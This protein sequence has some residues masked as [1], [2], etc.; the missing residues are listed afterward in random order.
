MSKLFP[1]DD[2]Q[3]ALFEDFLD[4]GDE[5][6]G[7]DAD[8]ETSAAP[9]TPPPVSTAPAVH[10][11]GPFGRLMEANFLQFASYSICD[12]ALPMVEDGLKP[13]QRRILHAMW[14]KDD[15]RFSKVA[16]VVG[17]TMHYH[18]HGDAAIKDAIVTLAN[19]RYL[20]QGQGNF[21][22]IFTGDEA[23]AARYIE[24]RLTK[25]AR[26]YLFSPKVTEYVP[27]Y[28]GRNKEPVLLPSK[29]P[30]S[31]MLGIDG[32][33][34]GLSTAIL[35]HNF[36]EL[37]EA[38]IAILQ[39]KPCPTLVPDF[40][41]GGIMDA[42]EYNDGNGSIRVR[43]NIE[44]REGEKNKLFIT[45][46]PYGVT[47]DRLAESIEKAIKTKKLPI[48]HIDNFTAEKV[49]IEISLTPGSDAEKVRKSLYAFTECER[50]ISSRIVVLRDNRPVE[51]SVSEM[52]KH[53]A[54]RLQEIFAAEFNVR[55]GEIAQLM[56]RKTLEAI[57]IEHR[58]YKR[59]ET[60][61][62]AE[63]VSTE[64]RLGFT[65]FI[66][67]VGHELTDDEIEMLLKIP[68][69]R[70]SLYDINRHNDEMEALRQEQAEIE[71]NLQHLAR[72]S[73]KFLKGLLKEFGPQY[74]RLTEI[75]AG[76]QEID[77]RALTSTELTMRLSEDFYFG[78]DIKQGTPL[79]PCSSLDKI[80]MVWSDGRYRFMPP[81]DKVLADAMYEPE[82]E[83]LAALKP[84]SPTRYFT[85]GIYN[86]DDV[87]T[88]IYYEPIYG[89]TYIKRFRWGGMIMNKDYSL[90]PENATI[91]LL[92]KGTPEAVYVKFKYMKGQRI[93][94][95]VFDPSEARITA[96][97][98][99]GIQMTPK[100]IERIDINKPTWWVATEGNT[101]GTLFQ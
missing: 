61:K 19:K 99:K 57:F 40:I 93:T 6:Q 74:P 31:L 50:K 34:V 17:N 36:A 7:A 95:Q 64:I 47:T 94:Q 52:L 90:V 88:C 16:G 71:D 63:G 25:L 59:I 65:P 28:D 44:Q 37:L 66:D 97:S 54:Q 22:N 14:E 96:A 35:P 87:F 85:A 53:H 73:T 83:W 42:S 55:L 49:E 101:K 79:F 2:Q 100:Q 78:Y 68:I 3:E 26:E 18:P 72:Y 41:T 10:D 43:A 4:L 91:L 39:K 92:C 60:V 67:Q 46:V 21:G 98:S 56:H 81:P 5:D 80:F 89:F 11:R 33:A 69:R 30:L 32:I 13:V 86:R 76:F 29:V 82:K 23:A 1:D 70:I 48:R 84:R 58:I 75:E 51:L 9:L 77:E 8:T 62:T 24:C 20:I 12:R 45:S 38:E 27:S 15:G